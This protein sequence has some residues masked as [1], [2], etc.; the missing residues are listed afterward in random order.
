MMWLMG[1]VWFI[2]FF[3][4]C[5]AR[6]VWAGRHTE[7]VWGEGGEVLDL[8][9]NDNVMCHDIRME[10]NWESRQEFDSK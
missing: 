10:R 4:V 2:D 3:C 8:E 5:V 1:W 9:W 7:G 6:P